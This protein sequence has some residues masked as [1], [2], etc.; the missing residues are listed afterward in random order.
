MTREELPAGLASLPGSPAAFAAEASAASR[1]APASFALGP[2]LVDI[3]LSAAH[4]GPVEAR[5][6]LVRRSGIRHFHECEAAGASR[7]PVGDQ[8]DAIYCSISFKQRPDCRFCGRKIQVAYEYVLHV[9]SS[10]FT[11]YFLIVR[12]T[13][14]KWI[15]PSFAGRPK[16]TF[17]L[18]NSGLKRSK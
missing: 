3:E 14:G 11:S 17:I 6:G 10:N 5:N 2:G 15:E 4:I 16:G 13:P 1:A 8:V 7:I 18:P 12:A 9:V